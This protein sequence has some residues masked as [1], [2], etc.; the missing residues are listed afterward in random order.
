MKKY[1]KLFSYSFAAV[2]AC[3]VIMQAINATGVS[4][5]NEE[6]M[7]KELAMLIERG[8]LTEDEFN[9]LQNE[10]DRKR[11]LQKN[12]ENILNSYRETSQK[13]RES[14]R[15]FTWLPWFLLGILTI[16]KN[17]VDFIFLMLFPV[18][19]AVIHV[20]APIDIFMYLFSLLLGKLTRAMI[21]R[22]EAPELL[23]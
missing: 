2:I 11:N 1:I 12:N 7:Q 23:K 16:G 18:L 6:I 8:P 22:K 10:Y 17:P 9:E 3:L 19:L 21:D 15:Y 13:V 20:F 14:S 5:G 4:A